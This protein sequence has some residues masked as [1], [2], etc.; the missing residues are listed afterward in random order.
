MAIQV[1]FS[2]MPLSQR[3][4]RKFERITPY[5]RVVGTL[6]DH[7]VIVL[8]ISVSDARI[9]HQARFDTKK[10]AILSFPWEADTIA[11]E[12]Q[13]LRTDIARYSREPGKTIYHS[14]VEFTRPLGASDASL[15]E[16][17]HT[18]VTRAL[19]EQKANARGIPPLTTTFLQTAASHAGYICCYYEN[20]TWR[21]SPTSKPDQPRNGFTVSAEEREED[22]EKLCKLYESSNPEEREMI[23]Q[24]AAIS[25]GSPE[26]F[27]TRRFNP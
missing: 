22:I 21:R 4:R 13:I 7:K 15:R 26:G 14:G 27:A 9:A 23:R 18:H 2:G 19:D 16:L 10:P 5:R 24:T 3:E 12:C 6:Q 25:V 20:N 1:L 17:I 8:E 11:F